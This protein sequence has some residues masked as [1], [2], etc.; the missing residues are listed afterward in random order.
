M[1]HY[2]IFE[3]CRIIIRL[4]IIIN[5]IL[6]IVKLSYDFKKYFLTNELNF[7]EMYGENSYAVIT[8]ASG[9]QGKRFAFEFAKRG[10]NLLLIGYKETINTQQ[11]INEVYPDIIIKIIVVD[12]CKAH[13]KKFFNKIE[14]EIK[15]IDVSILVNNIGHRVAW[16]PYHEMP[17]QKINDSIIC[18]TIVQSQM[19]RLIIPIFLKRKQCQKKS[20]LI[21]ITAQ[22]VYSNC[23][24]NTFDDN[25]LTLPY[26]SVYEAS[27]V[28]GYAHAMSIYKEYK[29]EFDI[30]NITPGAVVTENTQ[31]LH[32][33][34]LSVKC[35]YFVKQI[36]KL[37]GNV[38]GNSCGCWQHELSL[39]ILLFL[40]SFIKDK[41]LK[42]VGDLLA[43][44]YMTK[45]Y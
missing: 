16:N 21:F 24:I 45:Y 11:E 15:S 43:N 7:K 33:T 36:M 29:D 5:I 35:D 40:P 6:F 19:T 31:Y 20:A 30:L 42:D 4:L 8:G 34:I 41:L 1:N 17:A 28:F 14:K 27:N 25:I 3:K 2:R 18:G 26:V 38:Q 37:I 22:C 12:F 13:K 39:Y 10:L 23:F 32:S 9:G 44:E